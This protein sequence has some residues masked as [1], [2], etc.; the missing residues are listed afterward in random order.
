MEKKLGIYLREHWKSEWIQPVEF[1][2]RVSVSTY[3]YADYRKEEERR[4]VT[5]RGMKN[6][7]MWSLVGH[8]ELITNPHSYL[9]CPSKT[10]FI[11]RSKNQLSSFVI[12][13][14][15]FRYPSSYNQLEF[16]IDSLLIQKFCLGSPSSSS[17][18]IPLK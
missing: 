7:A 1:H 11:K 3:G 8:D 17:R 9:K 2:E 13:S 5:V 14:K 16:Q 6:V 15:N 12:L 10:H 18:F 4:E